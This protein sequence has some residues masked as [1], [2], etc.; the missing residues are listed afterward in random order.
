MLCK[1]GGLVAFTA[2]ELGISDHAIQRDKHGVNL[3]KPGH[4]LTANGGSE[5]PAAPAAVA[6]QLAPPDPAT[7][8]YSLGAP[9][10][11]PPKGN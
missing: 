8:Y 6:Q 9:K 2:S 3:M 5:A 4:G 11:Q 1:S 7:A 10:G